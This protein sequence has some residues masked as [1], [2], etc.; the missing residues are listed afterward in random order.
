MQECTYFVGTKLNNQTFDTVDAVHYHFLEV[1]V[2][3]LGTHDL[4]VLLFS[5]I[6][7]ALRCL[8]ETER[9]NVDQES[10]LFI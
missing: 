7:N 9:H 8:S 2:Q 3:T 5:V 1:D 10:Y 6:P 4:H